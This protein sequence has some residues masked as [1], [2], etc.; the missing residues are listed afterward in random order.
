MLVVRPSQL[1]ELAVRPPRVKWEDVAGCEDARRELEEAIKYVGIHVPS[2]CINSNSFLVKMGIVY[3]AK[4]PS[5]LAP[6]AGRCSS[7]RSFRVR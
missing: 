1:F 4:S 3:R 2:V 5:G 6:A 7:L